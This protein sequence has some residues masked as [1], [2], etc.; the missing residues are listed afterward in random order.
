MEAQQ[1]VDDLL[2]PCW[3]GLDAAYKAKYARNIWEQFAEQI[4]SA[5][6]TSRLATFFQT[7]T[8]RLNISIRTEDVERVNAVLASMQD[9]AILKMLRDETTMLVLMCRLKNEDRKAEYEA[10]RAEAETERMEF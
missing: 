10:A 7:L 4:A 3:R 5:A 8:Q 6:Y 2:W 9:R 1:I